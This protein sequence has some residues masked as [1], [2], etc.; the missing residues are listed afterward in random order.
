[1]IGETCILKVTD[2]LDKLSLL[3]DIFPHLER[4]IDAGDGANVVEKR[5]RRLPVTLQL[6]IPSVG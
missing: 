1:M 3:P 4:F 2:G 5:S 6:L